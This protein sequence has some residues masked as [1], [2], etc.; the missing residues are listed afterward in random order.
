M[1]QSGFVYA[2]QALVLL[3]FAQGL[4][5]QERTAMEEIVV[6]G[7]RE[8]VLRAETPASVSVINSATIDDVKPA[9]P[10]E[11]LNRVPGVTIQQT[12]GEGHI[13]GIRQPIGT[14]SVYLYLEDGVP[15]RASGF[16]NHN[17]L[18]EINMPM[19]GGIEVTR[20]PG[21]ALQGS[22]AIGGIVN[23][24]T[25]APAAE[26]EAS[27]TLEGGSYTWLRALGSASST[28][29]SFGLRGDVNV[30]H[31]DGWRDDT[32]Y[33]RQSVT[34][35]AD[36]LFSNESSIK[37]VFAASNIDQETGA[38]SGL[39]LADY[40]DNPTKNN[41][42][43]AF[44]KVRSARGSV[45]WSREDG[46]SLISII[47]YFRWSTM[48]LLAT[49]L[50]TS[51]PT[52]ATSGYSSLGTMAKYRY[53]FEPWRTRIIAGVD[54]DYSPGSREEDRILGLRTGSVY[55]AYTTEGRIYDYDVT[56][57]QVSPYLQVETSPVDDLRLT[58]GL[59]FDAMGYEYDNKL[60]DGTFTT[61]IP[62]GLRTFFRPVDAEVDYTRASPSIGIT[63]AFTPAL[64]AFASYKQSFRVPQEAN[65]FRQG[66]NIDSLGLK[67]VIGDSYEAGLRGML[68]PNFSWDVS[69]Y[70]MVKSDDIL[71][72]NTGIGPTQTNNGKSRH[73]GI[74]VAAGW[75]I[76]PGLQLDVAASYADHEYLEW[77]TSSAV[78]LSGNEISAAP[79]ETAN[80]TLKY[81]AAWLSG[82]K[83][84]AEWLHLGSYWLDDA[85]T[86][87]YGGHDLINL[88]AAYAVTNS[89][90]VFGRVT[91]LF[92]ATWSTSSSISGGVP[93]FAPGMPLSVYGG[94]TLKF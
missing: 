40:Q 25:R 17:A 4:P 76:V 35:R 68:G 14:S 37:A 16:F 59:R 42:P 86:Q 91:N 60:A 39:P 23:V 83:L 89:V 57:W 10:S 75:L 18:Y 81:T 85:N 45:E 58:A 3:L 7:S 11:I 51:D 27:V 88:R 77:V 8:G 32:A 66:T 44:R 48:D 9:H 46:P 69:L 22:D 49:F 54:L 36:K 79:R 55:T 71:T 28:W 34:L 21:T 78:V 94:V 47:P 63:Y 53:D 29:G 65:L 12:N 5:A 72:L 93:Q 41:F 20:G 2:G 43:I 61:G 92:D 30:T 84:E 64:N 67:P 1:E 56:F 24:L 73:R 62:A 80:A 52:N 38:N 13:T 31:S 74:E 82:L 33:D 19:S 6:T 26:P 87:K 15:V 90:E 50:L 70:N